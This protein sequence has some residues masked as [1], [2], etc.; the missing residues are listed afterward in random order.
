[1][2]RSEN[3]ILREIADSIVLV[4]VGT[5]AANF[6]GLITLNE[7]SAFIWNNIDE[8]VTEDNLVKL[9]LEE[10]EVDEET[11]KQDVHGLING[12]IHYGMVEVE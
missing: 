9:I 12:F 10:Y 8:C 1:M 11:A 3:F 2:K 5:N 4:P 7:I 6:N